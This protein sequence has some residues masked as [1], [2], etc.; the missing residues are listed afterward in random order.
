M[1]KIKIFLQ[2]KMVLIIMK[3]LYQTE[4]PCNIVNNNLFHHNLPKLLKSIKKRP[5]H[6]DQ[7]KR[8]V[9]QVKKQVFLHRSINSQPVWSK[10]IR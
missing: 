9:N 2:L 1:T 8:V 3:M 7:I 10:K 4:I 5:V 6:K